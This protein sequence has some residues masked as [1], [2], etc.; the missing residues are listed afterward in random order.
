MHGCLADGAMRGVDASNNR[1]VCTNVGNQNPVMTLDRNTQQS[2]TYNGG[3]HSVHVCPH[4][5]YM[6][7]WNDSANLLACAGQ[8]PVVFAGSDFVDNSSQAPETGH[9]SRTAH[10]CV[11]PDQPSLMVGI[12]GDD[13]KLICQ[14]I[15]L[16]QV[17]APTAV[18]VE[19]DV[20]QFD[21]IHNCAN[22]FALRGVDASNNRFFCQFSGNTSQVVSVDTA[23]QAVFHYKGGQHSVHVCPS[24]SYMRGW[25]DSGNRLLCASFGPVQTLGSP[26]PDD[27]SQEV[28]QGHGA[29]SMHVCSGAAQAVYMIGIQGDDNE[30]ICQ[31]VVTPSGA[32]NPPP[33]QF[34]MWATPPGTLPGTSSLTPGLFTM[35]TASFVN[36][37]FGPGPWTGTG[38]LS[39]LRGQ[40]DMTSAALASSN[41]FVQLLE[42]GI[43]KPLFVGSTVATAQCEKL[44]NPRASSA[45]QGGTELP[46]GAFS[47]FAGCMERSGVLPKH[48][49]MNIVVDPT[50]HPDEWPSELPC[51]TGNGTKGF[52]GY[53]SWTNGNLDSLDPFTLYFFTV[54]PLNNQCFPSNTSGSSVVDIFHV[55]NSLS[56]E[57]VEIISDPIS[58]RGWLHPIGPIRLNAQEFDRG[59]LGDICE[60]FGAAPPGVTT[61]QDVNV[62]LNGVAIDLSRYWSNYLGACIPSSVQ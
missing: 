31:T 25:D 58:P 1:F 9:G 54:V 34:V 57:M 46:S 16:A 44:F 36:V 20:T 3:Q 42:Y 43:Q 39:Q 21:F 53:H 22:G 48:Q 55:M 12:Q 49:F 60:Q 56:H 45:A 62:T 28:E 27:G 40:I 26:F 8:G 11:G 47:D 38:V 17:P 24:G 7:G 29:R 41:Y 2:V 6:V 4:G 30:L 23:T 33:N 5:T 37:Y 61:T 10:V 13:N 51:G 15:Q 32:A 18:D 14:S 59:E 52:D 35:S 19:D 50:T